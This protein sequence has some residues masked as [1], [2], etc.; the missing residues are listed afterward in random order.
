MRVTQDTP[1]RIVLLVEDDPAHAE[2]A[3]RALQAGSC[4]ARVVHVLDGVVAL[5]YV[6]R[7]G[8]Y[9]DPATSP[10]PDLVLL[11]LRLPRMDG[12]ELLEQIRAS[13]TARY[14]PVVVLS[15]SGADR[16]IALAYT[17]GANGYVVK[18]DDYGRLAGMMEDL[19]AFW[20]RWNQ[21]FN[22]VAARR[23]PRQPA[24][25]LADIHEPR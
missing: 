3:M 20:L 5:E 25:P 21:K 8:Q 24:A 10:T 16:D 6:L 2:L 17:A 13:D 9:A 14:L 11:D 4:P 15:T 12:L 1:A 22:L 7:H 19:G 23:A 18:P